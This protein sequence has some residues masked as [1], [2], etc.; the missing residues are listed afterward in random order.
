MSS[1]RARKSMAVNGLRNGRVSAM[2]SSAGSESTRTRSTS[3]DGEHGA[4]NLERGTGM[5]GVDLY[6]L[7]TG[8]SVWFDH[9]EAVMQEAA[10]IRALR[11]R[12]HHGGAGSELE[13]RPGSAGF[14]GGEGGPSIPLGIVLMDPVLAVRFGRRLTG[15]QRGLLLVW[16]INRLVRARK[17]LRQPYA[18]ARDHLS[19]FRAVSSKADSKISSLSDPPRAPSTGVGSSLPP[20]P[21]DVYV[22]DR[23]AADIQEALA[24][25]DIS[26]S[27]GLERAYVAAKES[28]REPFSAFAPEVSK[29]WASVADSSMSSNA[30]PWF[31][32]QRARYVAWW[33]APSSGD[34]NSDHDKLVNLLTLATSLREHSVKKAPK[35]GQNN[36]LCER[37]TLAQTCEYVASTLFQLDT[38]S[39]AAVDFLHYKVGDS[40]DG[41]FILPSG[42]D[43]DFTAKMGNLSIQHALSTIKRAA[44]EA[45]GNEEQERA[46]VAGTH[47]SDQVL[48]MLDPLWFEGLRREGSLCD[49]LWNEV[50]EQAFG[51]VGTASSADGGV[52]GGVL[53]LPGTDGGGVHAAGEAKTGRHPRK[54]SEDSEDPSSGSSRSGSGASTREGSYSPT[55]DGLVKKKGNSVRHRRGST[56]DPLVFLRDEEAVSRV[57]SADPL[58]ELSANEKAMLWRHRRRLAERYKFKA[59]PKLL[60]AVN[61]FSRHERRSMLELLKDWPRPG[62]DAAT[63]ILE[64]LDEA[65]HEPEVREFATL[66]L[67]ALSDQVLAS[68]LPQLVQAIKYE[69][70]HS[71]NLARF[72]IRRALL[73]PLLIGLPFF[74]C[75]KVELRGAHCSER[76]GILI[77]CYLKFCGPVQR[78]L[79]DQQAHLWSETGAFAAVAAAVYA[80]KGQGKKKYVTVLREHLTTLQRS[81]PAEFSLPIDPR[82]ICRGVK[83]EKC[84][85]MSSAKLPLWLVFEN[86]DLL[87]EDIMVMFK[88]GDDLR[89]DTMVLQLIRNMDAMWYVFLF[90]WVGVLFSFR[91]LCD[92]CGSFA[93]V[94]AAQFL[95]LTHLSLFFLCLLPSFYV[96]IVSSQS[97]ARPVWIYACCPTD[98]WRHGTMVGCWRL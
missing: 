9:L 48:S 86:A 5:G 46:Q 75:C 38:N 47:A 23:V 69:P 10:P 28:L 25:D 56:R 90:V 20:P 35:T 82:I 6:H 1:R 84:R 13:T 43:F 98:A 19:R 67:N 80:C 7:A 8:R 52:N 22:P 96:F 53:S 76:Y 30:A 74:W 59:L 42:A 95:L 87:G 34:R 62:P 4:G 50:L 49:A 45:P 72:L 26:S 92:A 33:M 81:L 36:S 39:T 58:H 55:R 93:L 41:S 65:F 68:C 32:W 14:G 88:A 44:A 79:V 71:S 89:Q 83:V 18:S 24:S 63:S 3:H 57:I 61:W 37:F 54:T 16:A 70:Y 40:A 27:A 77:M 97:G 85:V 12:V 11:R 31:Y 60:R 66:G 15:V 64:L 21:D 73:S 91:V 2:L 78:A 51:S 94:L 29:H 17:R